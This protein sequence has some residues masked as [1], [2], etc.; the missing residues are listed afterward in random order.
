MKTLAHEPETK[1]PGHFDTVRERSAEA[2]DRVEKLKKERAAALLDGA[3]FDHAGLQSAEAE[4][5]GLA[6][7]EQLAIRRERE[8]ETSSWE[9][10]RKAAVKRIAGL[11]TTRRKA[12]DEAESS[13]RAMVASLDA[14]E[15]ARAGIKSELEGLG[16]TAPMEIHQDQQDHRLSEAIS[17]VLNGMR[18][19]QA[20]RFGLLSLRPPPFK[21]DPQRPWAEAETPIT[22]ALR[23]KTEAGK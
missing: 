15:G 22:D 14:A 18:P 1:P 7:A 10:K 12:I 13:C 8:E 23:A 20:Q 4:A 19:Q 11:E 5:R 21:E 6:D 9:K 2:Q 16:L 17:S 3:D